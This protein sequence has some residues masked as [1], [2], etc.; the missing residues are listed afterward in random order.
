MKL[1][2]LLFL[3]TLLCLWQGLSTLGVIP[4]EKVP[5]LSKVILGIVALE[6]EGLPPGSLL[7][8]HVSESLLRVLAGFSLAVLAALPLGL[9]AGWS[10]PLRD[11]ITPVIELVRPVPPLAWIPI[12]VLWFGIGLPSCAFIIFLGAFFPILLSAISGVLSVEPIL[13]D[14]AKTLG[15]RDRDIL[16]K[17]LAPGALP[18]VITGMRIGLGVGWMTLVAAEFVGVKTGFGVGFMIMVARDLQRAD[19]I[20]AGMIVIGAIG[21]GM[22]GALRAVE[23]RV[24]RWRETI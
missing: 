10:R 13:V 19:L 16:L 24:L 3:F 2:N 4:E 14:A 6:T 23:R 8:R 18:S 11:Q 7:Y 22:D 21:Y 9:I 12:A 1:R 17:I 15:A 5:S 20:V